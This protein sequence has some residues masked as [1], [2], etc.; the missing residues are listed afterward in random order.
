MCG[1]EHKKYYINFFYLGRHHR[2]HINDVAQQQ[3]PWRANTFVFRSGSAGIEK[4]GSSF[5]QVI[6]VVIWGQIR[7][8]RVS[9]VVVL[10]RVAATARPKQTSVARPFG[11]EST[12]S[13]AFQ[14]VCIANA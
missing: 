9:A 3:Q 11:N 4:R 12:M 1:V 10:L 13:F 6:L 8:S 2:C 7:V 14:S 5:R